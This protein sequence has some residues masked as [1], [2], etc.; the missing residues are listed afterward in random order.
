MRNYD[1]YMWVALVSKITVYHNHIGVIVDTL[2]ECSL[3]ILGLKLDGS[4]LKVISRDAKN[5]FIP[6]KRDWGE[7]A[8]V[9][10]EGFPSNTMTRSA[11]YVAIM[12]SCS[13]MKPV[14]LAWRINL[15]VKSNV[16]KINTS[17]NR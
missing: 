14:F 1:N 3:L 11:K 7:L 13:T 10:T 2:T 8:V 5:L 15:T 9:S 4:L 12:K 17:C 6:V 16:H